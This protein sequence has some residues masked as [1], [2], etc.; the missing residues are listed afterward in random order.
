[1]F[2]NQFD[3]KFPAIDVPMSK[4]ICHSKWEDYLAGIGNKTG[5]K[6]LE[7]G[8]GQSAGT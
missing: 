4:D 5:M 7:M 1:L 2:E 3:R 6:V 8:S